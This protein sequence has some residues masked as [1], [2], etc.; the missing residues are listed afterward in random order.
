MGDRISGGQPPEGLDRLH[1]G[2]QGLLLPTQT[3]RA[4]HE[5]F[6]Q[7]RLKGID[8]RV[9]AKLDRADVEVFGG[10]AAHNRCVAAG[11]ARHLPQVQIERRSAARVDVAETLLFPVRDVVLVGGD[12]QNERLRPGPARRQMIGPKQPHL[13]AAPLVAAQLVFLTRDEP[14]TATIGLGEER[15]AG[16]YADG[17]QR[18]EERS[19]TIV[20][21]SDVDPFAGLDGSARVR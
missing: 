17:D 6:D 3:R 21:N 20:T 9:E 8:G 13:G 4:R 10:P 2:G 11:V 7:G 18:N 16:G 19:G 12:E 1:R 5:I 15:N 14:D